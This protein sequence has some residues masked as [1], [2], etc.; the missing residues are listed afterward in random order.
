MTTPV[1]AAQRV[2][3]ALVF[4]VKRSS[5]EDG[6]GI[7]TTIFLKGCPLRCIWCCNPEGQETYPELQNPF[8]TK[9]FFE[10]YMSVDQ[11][12]A[13]LRA[14]LPFFRTSGGGVTI[15]GG[16]PT[17]HYEFVRELLQRCRSESIHTALDTCGCVHGKSAEL[18]AE[19]DLLLYDIKVL[20]EEEH[21][22]M[23]SLSNRPILKNLQKVVRIGKPI[24]VRIPIVPGY[25]DSDR[26]ILGI[27]QFLSRL[28]AP[29]R[30][31]DLIGFHKFA[32]SK[33]AAL[34]KKHMLD[35][36]PA[37]S[38]S[39]LLRIKRMLEAFGLRVQIG[40]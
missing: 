6:P 15:A 16:E 7:R 19:A 32:V 8:E 38:E 25:T 5:F 37:P 30:R 34:K 2:H 14:D 35:T 20:N 39:E 22:R 11:V 13:I 23:T 24:I 31:V 12:M 26:N 27:G 4:N 29:V 21:V 40:G 3:K 28:P 10:R 9:E 36:I 18:L 33:Y 1:K 17:M